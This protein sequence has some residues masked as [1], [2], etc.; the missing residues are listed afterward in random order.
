MKHVEPA[1]GAAQACLSHAAF[2]TAWREGELGVDI[3]RAAAASL[4]SA[5]LLLPFVAVAIIGFG[6]GLVLW[7]W[8]RTGLA[9]GAFGVLAPRLIKRSAPGFLLQHI[10]EDAALYQAA[11]DCGA[12]KVTRADQR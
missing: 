6:I 3:D 8:L 2:V 5:R 11:I 9:V 7:G 4:V 1:S 10:A 12:L